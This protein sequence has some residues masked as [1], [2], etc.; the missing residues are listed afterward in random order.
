MLCDV[1]ENE[2]EGVMALPAV[3]LDWRVPQMGNE[4]SMRF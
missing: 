2:S 4:R 3:Q 1:N